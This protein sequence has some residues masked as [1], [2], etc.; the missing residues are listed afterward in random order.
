MKYL[1]HLFPNRKWF[2]WEEKG[3]DMNDQT[4][5]E[6]AQTEQPAVEVQKDETAKP[7]GFQTEAVPAVDP[8]PIG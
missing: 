6:V 3:K 1:E 2:I 8:K 5:A 7:E 4:L